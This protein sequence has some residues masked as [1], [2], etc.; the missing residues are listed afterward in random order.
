MAV[1]NVPNGQYI[2]DYVQGFNAYSQ[3]GYMGIECISPYEG[4]VHALYVGVPY[5]IEMVRI[6]TRLSAELSNTDINRI[7]NYA[8]IGKPISNVSLYRYRIDTRNGAYG[9]PP[10]EV[11]LVNTTSISYQGGQ[12]LVYFQGTGTTLD[13]VTT[14]NFASVIANGIYQQEPLDSFSAVISALNLVPY[15]RFP[16]TYRLT[17]CTAPSAPTEAVVGDTVT[18]PLSFNS[19][20]GIVN[21]SSDIYVTNNG[22]LVPSS[23]SDNILT[24]T[25][26]DPS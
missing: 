20:Y 18:V 10:G 13:S 6:S 9:S 16:I 3:Y 2:S 14:P 19:G 5:S 17:N 1:I 26:P 4:Y 23:Y 25:M 8:I 15:N 22:V 11:S 7:Y 21:P 12:Y 24:F